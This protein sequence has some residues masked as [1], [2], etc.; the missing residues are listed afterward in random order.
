[1]YFS[2]LDFFNKTKI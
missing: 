1:M 2:M